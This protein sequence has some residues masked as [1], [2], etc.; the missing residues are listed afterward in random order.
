MENTK[1]GL[2]S[3]DKG[4]NIMSMGVYKFMHL[5]NKTYACIKLNRFIDAQNA[6]NQALKL[7]SALKLEKDQL[8]FLLMLKGLSHTLRG[9][10]YLA[11]KNFEEMFLKDPNILDADEESIFD[12]VP[13]YMKNLIRLSLNISLKRN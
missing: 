11:L 12:E 4:I 9:N 13:E 7:K 2:R 8:A 1:K 5:I 6:L 10:C 3:S